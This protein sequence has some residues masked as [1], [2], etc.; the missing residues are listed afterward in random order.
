MTLLPKSYQTLVSDLNLGDPIAANF[1]RAT[2]SGPST[3]AQ[4]C[5][6]TKCLGGNPFPALIPGVNDGP[7]CGVIPPT[8]WHAEGVVPDRLAE[9]PPLN[10]KLKFDSGFNVKSPGLPARTG[11]VIQATDVLFYFHPICIVHFFKYQLKCHTLFTGVKQ[12]HLHI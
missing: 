3:D 1:I 5:L 12:A 9:V 11:E 10:M 7:E 8:V 6:F 4:L 2:Y